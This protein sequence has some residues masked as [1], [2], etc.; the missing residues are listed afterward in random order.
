MP[1]Q[2]AQKMKQMASTIFSRVN[3]NNNIKTIRVLNLSDSD[4]TISD[5]VFGQ[6]TKPNKHQYIRLSIWSNLLSLLA[7]LSTKQVNHVINIFQKC[8]FAE[9]MHVKKYYYKVNNLKYVKPQPY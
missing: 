9:W 2:M 8:Y 1:P 5:L 7:L 4:S 3:L 6:N